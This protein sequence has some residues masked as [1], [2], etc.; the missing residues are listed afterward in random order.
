MLFEVGLSNYL[1]NSPLP[2]AT[3]GDAVAV[4]AVGGETHASAGSGLSGEGFGTPNAVRAET[5]NDTV[6][7]VAVVESDIGFDASIS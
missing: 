1:R 4:S 3:V 7:L 5:G 6:M 2:P